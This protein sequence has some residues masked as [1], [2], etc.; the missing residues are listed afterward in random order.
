MVETALYSYARIAMLEGRFSKAKFG[1]QAEFSILA[2]QKT[3][4][5][6]QAVFSDG[7]DFSEARFN[8][9]FQLG[10]AKFQSL[11]DFTNVTFVGWGEAGFNL[12]FWWRDGIRRS[13][14]PLNGGDVDTLSEKASLRNA[15]FFSTMI[16][17]APRVP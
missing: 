10:M 5:F 2:F 3:A 16:F 11:S 7:V 8:G 13:S 6:L 15:L 9:A 17:P 4:N 14:K 12:I 1:G